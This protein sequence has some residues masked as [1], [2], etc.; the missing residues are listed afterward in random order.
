MSGSLADVHDGEDRLTV[1]ITEGDP[2]TITLIGEVDPHTAPLLAESLDTV[3]DQ[4]A[5]VVRIDG[6][7]LDFIDSSGLRVLVDAHRRLG[8][9]PTVLVMAHVSPTL[10][11]LLEVTGLDEHVTVE[12]TSS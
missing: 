6:R 11:R 5:T 7:R 10:R 12:S 3:I 9:E 2:P 4:G 1:E 8:S